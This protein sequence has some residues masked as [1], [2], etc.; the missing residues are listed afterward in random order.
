[1]QNLAGIEAIYTGRTGAVSGV[2]FGDLVVKRSPALDARFR[3]ELAAAQ[4]AIA[5]LPGRF[6]EAIFQS[7]A[8]VRDAQAKVRVVL[9]TLQT[10]VQPLVDAL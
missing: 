4:Q 8:A 7:P 2:G 1:M 9:A 5:A 6:D 3:Q 10:V